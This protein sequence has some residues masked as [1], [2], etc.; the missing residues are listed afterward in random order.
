MCIRD[1]S[2]SAHG[3]LTKVADFN[4]QGEDKDVWYTHNPTD[5]IESVSEAMVEHLSKQLIKCIK[6]VKE[7]KPIQLVGLVYS[8]E[9]VHCG[10][11]S[12]VLLASTNDEINPLDWE[13]YPHTAAWPVGGR[14]GK[15]T[16]DLLRR[17][18]LVVESS[19][20]YAEDMQP[21]PYRE[22]LWKTCR[23]VVDA[24]A[25]TRICDDAVAVIPLDDHGDVDPREDVRESL[26]EHI[27]AKVIARCELK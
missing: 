13:E 18:Q 22:V 5:T 6:A 7:A 12:Q 25:K 1:S 3:V 21:K 23:A 2:Y 17:L 26:P 4:E 10:L 19:S 8:A 9:H 16:D 11:P 20:E 24:L 15:K 27:A 14:A